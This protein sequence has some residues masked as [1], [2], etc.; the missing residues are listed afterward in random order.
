MRNLAMT[1]S[2]AIAVFGASGVAAQTANMNASVTI[3]TL[4]SITVNQPGVT[5]GTPTFA[6]YDAGFIGGAVSTVVDTWANV[7]H[8]VSI[9]TTA[10]AMSYTGTGTDPLKAV[11][12]LQWN[13]GSGFVGLSNT[14]ADVVSNLDPGTHASAATVT[15]RMLLTTADIPGTYELGFTYTVVAN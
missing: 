14:A 8:D 1:L 15:Y 10:T 5:F 3:P 9:A 2:A 4:L 7:S 12:D 11:G 13:A 6:D